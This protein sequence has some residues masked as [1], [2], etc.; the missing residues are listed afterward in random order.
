MSGRSL[1]AGVLLLAVVVAYL[2]AIGAGYVWD[3]DAHLTANDTLVS[4]GGLSRIWLRPGSTPQYYPLVFTSFWLEHRA[5]GPR[6]AGYHIVNVLLHGLN[7]LLVWSVLR[8]LR[9]PGAW[10]AAALFA[11]HP[12]HVES[13]AWITERKNLLSGF[14]YLAAMLAWF[15]F[16]PPDPEERAPEGRWRWYA[17]TLALFAAAL[18]SKTVTCSLPAVLILVM[19][20]RRRPL[21]PRAL[22]PLAPMF[23]LGAGMALLTIRMEK[24]H[25]G[26]VGAE[27]SLSWLERCLVA[28]RALW[29]YAGKLIF[30]VRLTF[31]YPRWELDTHSVAQI[32]LP[33]AALAV[34]VILWLLRA[35]IGR[36]PLAASLFFSGTLLPALG[37][38]DVYPMRFSFVADHFQYLASLGLIVP[39][40]ATAT[41]VVSRSGAGAAAPRILGAIVLLPLALLT[42]RQAGIYH[43]ERTL[44][45][46]TLKKNPGAWIAENNLGLLHYRQGDLD[47]A[48]KHFN[49]AVAL[50]PRYPEAQYNL[51]LA[52]SQRGDPEEAR[53]HLA[54]SAELRP[55]NP[56]THLRLGLVLARLGRLAEAERHLAS[57]AALAP[58]WADAQLNLGATYARQGKL[59]EAADRFAEAVRLDPESKEARYNLGLALA[60]RGDPAE[61]AGQFAEAL[62]IDPAFAEAA[63]QASRIA[64]VLATDPDAR[65]R[66]GALALRLSRVASAATS[67]RDPETLDALA[68]SL[69]ETG[70]YD[71]A[72]TTAHRAAT[73]AEAMGR[74]DLAAA[75]SARARI[76]G[77]HRPY[78]ED[79]EP[80]APPP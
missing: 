52:L 49:R 67:D 74:E 55:D 30:P 39:A 25:I 27:W 64:W 37:F 57:A 8:R 54:L 66:D 33:L 16:S 71:G 20:W 24:L 2:P 73:M 68:A 11:L 22:L 35:R 28:G 9:L 19:W 76:Y 75:I 69:A 17:V 44:W 21:S 3:D 26:A 32:L 78:R 45:A 29:F 15:R 77:T 10:L 60:Q 46:D 34:F 79:R 5:W 12:V 18:L 70:D 80:T 58:G 14:F 56:E 51:G 72:V 40:A 48:L 43:D 59:A 13:V 1:E 53:R 36:G 38:F 65:T 31:I 7:A 63:R 62:R 41:R 42:W 61:A 23:A 4:E 6:P 47:T 50:H